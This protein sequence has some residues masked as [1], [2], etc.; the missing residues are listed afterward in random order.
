MQQH[1]YSDPRGGSNDDAPKVEITPV[2]GG[3]H[4]IVV[5][6]AQEYVHVRELETAYPPWLIRQVLDLKGPGYVCDEIQRDESP[7]YT[8]AALKTSLLGYI[9][10]TQFAGKRI[11]DFGCGAG[12]STIALC[13]MFPTAAV[14]GVELDHRSLDVARARSQFY[15]LTNVQYLV[16][17]SGVELP[18]G[19]GEFDFIVMSGV[20]EHL[21]PDERPAVMSRLWSALKPGGILFLRETPH[22]YFPIETHTTGLPLIN[23]LPRSLVMPI[24]RRI[25]RGGTNWDELLRRGIRG[26]SVAEIRKLVPDATLL[27]PSRLGM[28][29]L[30]DL[31][32]AAVPKSRSARM[33]RYVRAF[34]KALTAVGI[35]W[36]PYLEL[37]L[38]KPAAAK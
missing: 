33:K 1:E 16:S 36:P 5:A 35:E 26:G 29:D 24:V 23:Y 37:A 9:S 38:R 32:Y 22:R 6:G 12:A 28:K 8:G 30:I 4:R 15:G 11:L 3:R 14:V 27:R 34:A 18:A 7:E 20:F 25:P 2:A 19:L 31:W 13:R 10:E 17:P 21:L